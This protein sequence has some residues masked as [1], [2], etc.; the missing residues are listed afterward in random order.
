[1]V[2]LLAGFFPPDLSL[3]YLAA[4]IVPLLQTVG[5]AAG[6]MLIACVIGLPLAIL[7]VVVVG[8]G[9]AAGMLALAVFYA[10]MIGKVFADLF[11]AADWRPSRRCAALARHG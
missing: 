11:L 9:P 5:M 4:M 1:V 6:G 8:I 2:S 7:C 10:A 3:S